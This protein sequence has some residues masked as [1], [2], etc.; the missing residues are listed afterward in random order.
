MLV[1]MPLTTS[2]QTQK[3]LSLRVMS[4]NMKEGGQYAG[5]SA[6]KFIDYIKPYDPDVIVLQ[7]MDNL[8]IRN[9]YKDLLTEIANGTNMFP[10]YCKSFTYQ[11]GGFGVAVLSKYPYFKAGRAE[12]QPAGANEP[13]ACGWVYVELPDGN[14]VRVASVHLSV[15]SADMRVKNIAVYNTALFKDTDT[16]TILA[17]DFNAAPGST[18]LEYAKINW[19]NVGGE[20]GFTIPSNAPNRRL[21]YIMGYPKRWICDNI[22]IDA[23]PGLSDH[24]FLIADLRF[25]VE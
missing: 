23:Q 8:T 19:Q 5:Y 10:Y 1:C 2:A 11:G 16:P 13:R 4:M 20:T 9:G 22:M 24:C 18:E 7:E 15:E 12:S 17:G 21:D 6:Q 25:P 14:V 3:Y